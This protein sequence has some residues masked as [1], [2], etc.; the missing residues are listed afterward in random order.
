MT[1][2]STVLVTYPD[3]GTAAKISRDLVDRRMAACAN[4]FPVR[5]IYRWKEEVLDEPEVAVIYKIASSDFEAFKDAVVRLHPYE[6]PCVV[7]YDIAEG[8]APYLEWITGSTARPRE[9]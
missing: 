5:S 2:A 8:H 1:R 9:D 7:R 4:I 3:E 6:V